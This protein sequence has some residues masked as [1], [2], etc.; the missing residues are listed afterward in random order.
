MREQR[1]GI[2]ELKANLSAVLRDVKDGKAIVITERGKTI[3]RILPA[4]ADIEEAL[5]QGARKR[6]WSWSGRKWRP[7]PPTTRPR[8]SRLVSDLLLDDRE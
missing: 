5:E 8:G 6:F 7:N 2:R 1:I 3:G 4:E